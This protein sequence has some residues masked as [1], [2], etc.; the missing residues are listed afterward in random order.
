MLLLLLSISH[1]PSKRLWDRPLRGFSLFGCMFLLLWFLHLVIC[2]HLLSILQNFVDICHLLA[3]LLILS[4]VLTVVTS[5]T[6]VS[7]SSRHTHVQSARFYLKFAFF[8]S[9]NLNIDINT[10]KDSNYFSQTTLTI[11]F[12]LFKN[13]PN[14]KVVSPQLLVMSYVQQSQNY[15]LNNELDSMERQPW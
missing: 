14:K 5:S 11:F 13:I 10:W 9:H 2:C 4:L 6:R 1:L 3:F 7:R 15:E 12:S 8:L